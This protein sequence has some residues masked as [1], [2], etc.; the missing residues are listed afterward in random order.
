MNLPAFRATERY[1]RDH[2]DLVTEDETAY[3]L[4]YREKLAPHVQDAKARRST[5]AEVVRSGSA[6]ASQLLGWRVADQL[7]RLASA[8]PDAFD[9]AARALIEADDADVFWDE[10]ARGAGGED[11]LEPYDKVRSAGARASVAALLLFL[12]EPLSRPPFRPS[13]YGRPLAR[14]LDLTFDTSTPGAYLRGYYEGVARLGTA[15]ENAGLP[16]RSNLDVQGVLWIVNYKGVLPEP[17]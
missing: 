5:W 8:R 10:L 12:H 13:N 4:A 17:G 2:W 11:A 3:K 9:T 6:G 15:L 7:Q 1:M 16:V 14:I